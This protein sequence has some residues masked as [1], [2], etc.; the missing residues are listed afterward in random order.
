MT[1][2][3]KH[4]FAP[5]YCFVVGLLWTVSIMAFSARAAAET[6][7]N[8]PIDLEA[9]I[10]LVT[11]NWPPY[12]GDDLPDN[13]LISQIVSDA[14]DNVDIDHSID[15]FPWQRALQRILQDQEFDA[16]YPL[17]VT[18]QRQKQFLLSDPIG[19][20][21]LGFVHLKSVHLDWDEYGDLKGYLIGYV[22]GYT[23]ESRLRMMLESD[24]LDS[25]PAPDDETL[26]RQ[27]LAGH[28]EIALIDHNVARYLIATR[29]VLAPL[30]E[31]IVYNPR[32]VV[33][34]SLHVGFPK[35]PRG[36]VLLKLF[37]EGL[38]DL[39]CPPSECQANS[40]LNSTST[41]HVAID[42]II[43]GQ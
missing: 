15:V 43:T 16:V 33:E 29:P 34:N 5:G 20:S 12:T 2:A 26:M 8:S 32:L 6:H 39:P 17:Y 13:G 35:T 37:N 24:R 41:P 4:R 19:T 22:L 23:Y 14:F 25:R 21:P 40:Y 18:P 31:K 7:H 27:I 30:A 36:E 1:T 9:E 38:G 10:G 11:L 3:A 42:A 28:I